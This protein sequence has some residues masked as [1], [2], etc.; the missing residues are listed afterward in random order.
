VLLLGAGG[1]ARAIAFTLAHKKTPE[2]IALLDVDAGTLEKLRVDLEEGT[3]AAIRAERMTDASL[4]V[5]IGTADLV[6]HCTPVGMSP[7]AD[8]SLVPAHLF[9]PGQAVFDI[10]YTPLETKLLRDAR[11]RGLQAISGVDMFVNQA[12]LQFE[13]FTGFAAPVEVMRRVV[14]S[15][16]RR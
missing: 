11:S 12:A 7:R 4:A 16:L 9:R 5:A 10:V 6:I 14:M 15:R 3:A 2:E 1:A 8:A 13:R